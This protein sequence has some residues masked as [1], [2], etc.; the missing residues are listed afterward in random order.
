[1]YGERGASQREEQAFGEPLPREARRA[2]AQGS[3]D[4]RF[5]AA[6]GRSGGGRAGGGGA[7]GGEGGAGGGERPREASTRSRGAPRVRR[8]RTAGRLRRRRASAASLHAI[9]R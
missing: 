9:A 8:S 7:G 5:A 3:T 1:G 6:G 2:G 4:R